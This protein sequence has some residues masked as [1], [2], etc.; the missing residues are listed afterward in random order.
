M[1]IEGS[2][3]F[4]KTLCSLTRLRKN[5]LMCRTNVRYR[6][7]VE[8]I[9]WSYHNA[10][11]DYKVT[12]DNICGWI[13]DTRHYRRGSNSYYVAASLCS[14]S[15]SAEKGLFKCNYRYKNSYPRVKKGIYTGKYLFMYSF[16]ALNTQ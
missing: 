11:G 6:G 8:D 16:F 5:H 10:S 9:F 14:T 12:K 3:P 4:D 13:E 15:M 2:V 1:D 7:K